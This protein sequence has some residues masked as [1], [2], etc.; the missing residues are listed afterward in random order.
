MACKPFNGKL[1]AIVRKCQQFIS[2]NNSDSRADRLLA[3][4][5]ILTSEN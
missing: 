2:A 1:R 3:H 4:M 5:L